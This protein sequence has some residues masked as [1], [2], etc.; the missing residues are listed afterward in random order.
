MLF[1]V[2]F[3]TA[4]QRKTLKVHTNT[5]SKRAMVQHFL[6][7]LF[8]EIFG[9][10]EQEVEKGNAENQINSSIN[11]MCVYKSFHCSISHSTFAHLFRFY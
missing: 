11:F 8:I 3:H 7:F 4:K 2:T 9:A 6:S 5:R 10:K 1:L